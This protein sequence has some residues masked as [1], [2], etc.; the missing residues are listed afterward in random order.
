MKP[1]KEIVRKKRLECDEKSFISIVGEV[2][3]KGHFNEDHRNTVIIIRYPYCH[4]L[5]T[6]DTQKIAFV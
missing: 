3:D 1:F 4:S 5:C 6:R 2:D